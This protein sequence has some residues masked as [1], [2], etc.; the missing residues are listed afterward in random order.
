MKIIN[1]NYNKKITLKYKEKLH[2]FQYTKTIYIY[3]QLIEV[4]YVYFQFN[5]K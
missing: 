4:R 5:L 2:Q 1:N 3:I